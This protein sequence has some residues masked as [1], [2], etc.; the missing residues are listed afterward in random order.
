VFLKLPAFNVFGLEMQSLATV[1]A[2]SYTLL[3]TGGQSLDV[4]AA[5]AAGVGQDWGIVG[6]S[7]AGLADLASVTAPPGYDINLGTLI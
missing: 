3:G 7:L 2:Y 6:T 5:L 4:I 1:S